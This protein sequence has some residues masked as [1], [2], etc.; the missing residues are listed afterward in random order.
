MRVCV[1]SGAALAVH[2]W[3]LDCLD[4]GVGVEAGMGGERGGYGD[5][6]GAVELAMMGCS[7]LSCKA[8]RLS[9]RFFFPPCYVAQLSI[10]APRNM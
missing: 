4:V 7:D 8:E 1:K 10:R 5:V 9:R 6:V 3:V 2:T